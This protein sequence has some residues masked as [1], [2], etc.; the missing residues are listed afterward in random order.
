MSRILK[1]NKISMERV[2]MNFLASGWGGDCMRKDTE[3]KMSISL[4]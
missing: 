4:M 3:M 2:E 1:G